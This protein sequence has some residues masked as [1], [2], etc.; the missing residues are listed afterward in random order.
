MNGLQLVFDELPQ[1]YAQLIRSLAACIV[2]KVLA[3][4]LIQRKHYENMPFKVYF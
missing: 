3:V 4:H 1:G 2:E